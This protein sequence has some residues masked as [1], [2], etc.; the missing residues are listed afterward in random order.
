MLRK[1]FRLAVILYQFVSVTMRS[2]QT[3]LGNG[4]TLL[5][6]DEFQ[7]PVVRLANEA[8][9]GKAEA[10]AFA[11]IVGGAYKWLENLVDHIGWYARALIDDTN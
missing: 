3:Q 7:A 9:N 4:A 10:S 1:V 11:A 8:G 6:G 5:A 2:W